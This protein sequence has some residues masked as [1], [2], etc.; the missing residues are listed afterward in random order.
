MSAHIF[1][2][3]VPG[4]YAAT[5]FRRTSRQ[6]EIANCTPDFR[7]TRSRRYTRM[8]SE[9]WVEEFRELMDAARDFPG[10]KKATP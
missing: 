5:I 10:M 8:G 9:N 4:Y 6:F 7:P 2:I 1:T 3:F